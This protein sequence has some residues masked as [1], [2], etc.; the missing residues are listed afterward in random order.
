MS[1]LRSVLRGLLA[2]TAA[3]FAAL[4]GFAQE[5]SAPTIILERV[6]GGRESADSAALIAR[7][8]ALGGC[9]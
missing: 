4:P 3:A 9:R 7:A 5:T 1:G 2:V 8:R 6:E